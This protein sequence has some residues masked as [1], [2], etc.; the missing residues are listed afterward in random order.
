MKHKFANKFFIL[1]ILLTLMISLA[2][3]RPVQ[4]AGPFSHTRVARM[5][6]QASPASELTTLPQ[7]YP[8][9]VLAGPLFPDWGSEGIF[10]VKETAGG[11]GDCSSWDN[12]CTLQT[13]LSAAVSGDE[14]WVAAGVHFPGAA[15]TDT[16]TLKSG[17]AVYGGFAGTE[18]AREQRDPVANPTILS[19]DI[20]DNDW[21][22]NGVCLTTGEVSGSNSYHVVTGGGA[23]A[24]AVLDGFTITC[25][26]AD[27]SSL[28]DSGGGMYNDASS[29]SLAHL[30]FSGNWATDYGG[31]MYN[32]SD[33]A[34]SSNPVLTDVT[35]NDNRA[36][37]YGGGMYNE[38]GSPSLANV[39]FNGNTANLY[40]GGIYNDAS[41]PVLTNVIFNGNTSHSYGG[42][43]YNDASSPMLTNLTFSG[44]TAAEGGGMCNRYASNPQVHNTIF[45]GNAAEYNGDQIYNYSSTPLISYSNIQG[46]GGSGSAWDTGLGTD[47][48]GNIDADP[49]FVVPP[50]VDLHLGPGS[51]AIDTGTNSGCPLTDLDGVPRPQDGNDDRLAICDMGAYE[52][53]G[54]IL[55]ATHGGA[56]LDNCTSWADACTL[57]AALAQAV[58]EQQIWVAA[59]VHFPGTV[60]TDTFTLKNGVAVYGGFD[61]TEM[62][63]SK[64][65]PV[66][67]PTILSGD[68]DQNDTKTNGV[69]L[70][71]Y[72]TIFGSNSYHV[73]TG[74]GTDATAVLDGFTITCGQANGSSPHDSGGGMRNESGSPSLANLTFSGNWADHYGGGM[75]NNA[76]NPS[77]ADL[78]FSGNTAGAGG[79]MANFGGS[80]V[81]T[82]LTFNGNT[83]TFGG[84]IYSYSGSP[85]LTDVIFSGNWANLYGGGMINDTSSPMLTNVIFSSNTADENGGGIANFGGSPVLTD[86]T[87]NGN[88]ADS[89][90]GMFNASSNPVLTDVTFNGNTATYGGGMCNKYASSPSLANVTF[91]GNTGTYGGGM[92]NDAGSPVLT[93]II[94]NDNTA[95]YGGGIFNEYAS[96]PSLAN[97]T[98]S[99]NTADENGGGIYNAASG[100]ILTNV[101][102]GGNTANSGGGMFNDSCSP[103]VHNAIFWGNT[104][105]SGPQIS[106]ASSTPLISYSDIQGS[107][108]SGS[109]W[110]TGL[111][112]D[113]GGNIDANPLFAD[114]L[115]AD[116]HLL[117]P[118]PAL[119]AGDNTAVPAD[120]LDLDDDGDTSEPLPFDLDG[121]PRFLD[122]PLPDAGNGTPPLVDM[123]AYEASYTVLVISDIGDQ[124][125]AEDT[126]TAPITFT[127]GSQEVDP[128]SL[129]LTADSSDLGLIPI[130]NILFGGTGADRTVT[131][132]PAADQNGAAVIT[133]TV[134]DGN[135]STSDSFTLTV[136]PVNDAPV[137]GDITD[138]AVDEGQVLSFS[139]TASDV[140]LP[141]NTLTFSLE[142]GAPAGAGITAGGL[143]TWT[144]GESQGP[145]VYPI[146]VRVTDDGTPP[147]FDNATFT[148]TVA[149][150][151]QA[152]LALADAYTTTEDTPLSVAA[153]GLLANDSDADLPANAL[154]VELVAAPPTGVLALN[155]DG[156]FTYSPALNA[157]G[158]VTFSYRLLDG[159]GGSDQADVILT[160]TPLND[161]PAVEAGPD[162]A[163]VEG[164]PIAFAGSF[165]DPGLLAFPQAGETIAWDF[166]DGTAI[167]G[168]LTPTHTYLENG[169]YTVTLTITDALG[170]VGQDSL[171]VTVANAAPLL[172]ALDDLT[173]IQN[174]ELNLS[175]TY[176]DAGALDT[177]TAQI[178]WG[179]GSVTGGVVDPPNHLVGGSHTYAAPGAYTLTL[180][181]TD[182]DGGIA[183]RTI[184]VTVTP[185]GYQIFLPAVLR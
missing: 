17:V 136:T 67:N 42:G 181:L 144:P 106:N 69:C 24:T 167:S 156:S 88:T 109:A 59:G 36:G 171:L 56:G 84:G 35:F 162:Q 128:I 46:S 18:T 180:T 12:A 127:V 137:L 135:I 112:I 130:E 39:I 19:G 96:S 45:W 133:L 64:R 139:A 23:D 90:G 120:S 20:D 166:G 105:S 8:K 177:H 92:Y 10:Y 82:D 163:A 93:N 71:A 66:A 98:F 43:I 113:G 141:A 81:L 75:H 149:E 160:I 108:G 131:I 102:F 157:N 142:A 155:P 1:S 26:W 13:A 74:S 15:R 61:G 76:G 176:T 94:F 48:G 33:Y 50:N 173:V 60:R 73:V 168:V 40:G 6:L 158:V 153:P 97:V 132:T 44:N 110:D 78:T 89:G 150:T 32:Y 140:D 170:G 185:A 175:V 34:G 9:H 49:L 161:A 11:A 104:A 80:P 21:D 100:T 85:V 99:G 70:M 147:L 77:L 152:P 178:D 2:G 14:I 83:A 52:A 103:Q 95:E 159:M 87:F 122:T 146:S 16:F 63:R 119:D 164:S 107:G 172:G 111:G 101:T 174:V 86:L 55:F 7:H 126:P 129:T 4:A 38:A 145:G 117:Y 57:Q 123:G 62:D 51:P 115:N 116:L 68:I 53:R 58:S 124:V 65:D 165:N 72:G 169:A 184:Q 125:T 30:T 37:W 41:N 134:S 151:N 182:D 47:G 121:S 31:G 79:G 148:V 179:D 3:G 22:G 118:S 143:F 25:G 138:Q 5:A 91:S 183:T 54:D 28:R 154:S 27:G 114:A 29:P